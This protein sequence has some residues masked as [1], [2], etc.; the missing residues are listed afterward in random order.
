VGEYAIPPGLA[1]ARIVLHT[2]SK[3]LSNQNC[4]ISAQFG[5]IKVGLN[6]RLI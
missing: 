4:A 5:A 6:D 2:P 3:A 1:H